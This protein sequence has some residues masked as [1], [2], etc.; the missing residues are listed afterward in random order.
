VSKPSARTATHLLK[1]RPYKTTVIHAL[2]P[3]DP[4][5]TVH[6][7]SWFVQGVVSGGIDPQLIL[8]SDEE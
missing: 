1:R 5:S 2:Q 4:G 7:C 8:F 6:F 3:R